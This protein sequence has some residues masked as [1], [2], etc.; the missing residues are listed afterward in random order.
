MSTVDDEIWRRVRTLRFSGIGRAKN[1]QRKRTLEAS[2]E[3]AEQLFLAGRIVGTSARPIVLFYGMSQLGR[4][5][6]AAFA[7]GDW[8]LRGHGI[9]A[10]ATAGPL[11]RVTLEGRHGA[12][13][14]VSA[15]LKSSTL[16][17]PVQLGELWPLL[18]EARTF[19]LSSTSDDDPRPLSLRPLLMPIVRAGRYGGD[20]YSRIEGEL[21]GLPASLLDGPDPRSAISSYLQRFP[22]LGAP[23]LPDELVVSRRPNA[24][25]A[26]RLGW[27]RHDTDPRVGPQA[28]V[29]V[30]SHGIQ[31]LFASDGSVS[32]FPSLPGGEKM[33]PWMTWWAVLFALSVVARYEPARWQSIADVDKSAEAVALEHVLQAAHSVVPKAF[34][35]IVGDR[36]GWRGEARRGADDAG[37]A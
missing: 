26:T 2:L 28:E 31:Y 29:F 1:G 17:A 4:A 5:L 20:S 9:R 13:R 7:D 19:P 11:D 32:V 24:A 3:Q 10:S 12:F 15:L 21:D 6:A 37:G 33:H 22:T 34:Y 18:P 36:E 35:R 8:E 14:V 23:D 27:R 25:F 16:E 30:R